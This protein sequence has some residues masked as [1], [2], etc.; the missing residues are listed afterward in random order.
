MRTL[1]ERATRT[2][3]PEDDAAV[4]EL[5]AIRADLPRIT[6][7]SARYR[8]LHDSNVGRVAKLEDLTKRF[9]D[10]RYDTAASEFVNS[11]LIAT[12]LTQLLAGSLGVPDVWDAITKQHR[13]RTLADPRFGSGGFPRGGN[14]WGGGWPKGGG[15]FGGGGFGRGGGGFG[16]GGFGRGGGFGGGGFRSGRGF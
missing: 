13:S 11:A 1:R 6:D 2:P 3:S 12:L 15:S 4:D 9:K 5:A 10:Q 16:G 8:A 14:P 7:E